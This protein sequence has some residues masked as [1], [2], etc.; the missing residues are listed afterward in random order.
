MT[1]E[2]NLKAKSSAGRETRREVDVRTVPPMRLPFLKVER[3]LKQALGQ[4]SLWSR[5]TN[6]AVGLRLS[7]VSVGKQ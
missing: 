3:V 4:V 6:G 5:L 7:A 2:R 1:S